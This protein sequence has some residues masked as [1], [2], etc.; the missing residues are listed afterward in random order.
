M[1]AFLRHVPGIL[2]IEAGH[3]N[4]PLDTG[5]ETNF[6]ITI[7]V[8][9]AYGYTGRMIDMTVDVAIRI[10]KERYWDMIRGDDI[11]A[12]SDKIVH[13][14]FDTSVNMGQAKAGEFLQ[15]S[16]NALNQEQKLYP[17][18]KVDGLIGRMTVANLKAYLS[19]RG[20]TGETVMWRALNSLQGARYIG[21]AEANPSQER[22][23]YGWFDHRVG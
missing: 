19:K 23:V 14:L 12:M 4:D 10:Y 15:R 16:L 7:A 22:F 21:I 11:A 3:S 1:E 8:A 17:D 13:E 5:G 2:V 9:R 20:K 18:T 6:G